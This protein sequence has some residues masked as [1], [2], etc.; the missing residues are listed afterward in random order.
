LVNDRSQKYPKLPKDLKQKVNW[1][2][3][4]LNE[5]EVKLTPS[6]SFLSI[7][8]ENVDCHSSACFTPNFFFFNAKL[9]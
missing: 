6:I 1:N 2:Q 4:L 9:K 5:G 3:T 7:E 8:V